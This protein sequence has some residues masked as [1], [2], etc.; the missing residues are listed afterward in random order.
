LPDPDAADHET[1]LTTNSDPCPSL[2]RRGVEHDTNRST[3]RLGGKRAGELGTD[4]ARVAVGAGN[5]APDHSDLGSANLLLG[6]VDIRN[7]LAEVEVGSALVVN[8]LDLDQARLGVGGVSR[9]L[10][11]QVTT[12]AV[13]L[14]SAVWSNAHHL[15]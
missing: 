9:A 15:T 6:L 4:D 14:G 2:Y 12:P 8:A 1:V 11:A 5:L 10:V 13:G 3:E 7:L